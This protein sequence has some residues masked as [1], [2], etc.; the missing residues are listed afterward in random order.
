MKELVIL[1]HVSKSYGRFT[2]LSE[3]N[4]LIRCGE[5]VAITGSNGAG[6]S[7]LL[8]L[9]AG[10]AMPSRG[11]RV[12]M[13]TQL[14][15]GY[16]PEKF[17]SLR[18]SPKQY[19][20]HIARIQGMNIQSAIQSIDSLLTLF[21]MQEHTERSM[22]QFSKGMLQKVNL[23]QALLSM[24]DLLLLDEPLSGLDE[25]SQ[26]EIIA[27]LE[28]IKRQGT[29]IVMSVHE[30][31]LTAVL[32]DRVVVMKQGKIT[33]DALSEYVEERKGIRIKFHSSSPEAMIRME[34]INGFQ[35]WI[36]RGTP[37]EIV[38][39]HD[40]SDEFLLFIL[41][42]GGSVISLQSIHEYPQERPSPIFTAERQV[43]K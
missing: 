2:A 23:M 3:V 41:T 38:I 31:L 36:S 20:L 27:V 18:F 40:S 14:R 4:W 5:C 29:A 37:S 9:I 11:K 8:H 32:A 39:N 21:Q 16:V 6:K 7:T 13:S 24:P 42:T 30:P 34:K 25:V 12:V 1:D 22:H 10:L 17:P 28:E 43:V 33:R 19:L 35:Y 26:H 15:T